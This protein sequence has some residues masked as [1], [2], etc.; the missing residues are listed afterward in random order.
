MNLLQHIKFGNTTSTEWR[1]K[2]LTKASQACMRFHGDTF[3]EDRFRQWFLKEWDKSDAVALKLQDRIK[4]KSGRD[5]A[6]CVRGLTSKTLGVFKP[7]PSK[8]TTHSPWCELEVREKW[9][10]TNGDSGDVDIPGIKTAEVQTGATGVALCAPADLKDV[11]S[12]IEAGQPLSDK[13]LALLLPSADKGAFVDAIQESY[14][15]PSGEDRVSQLDQIRIYDPSTKRQGVRSALLFQLGTGVVQLRESGPIVHLAAPVPTMVPVAIGASADWLEEDKHDLMREAPKRTLL[16]VFQEA[17]G[18]S[19]PVASWGLRHHAGKSPG[20]EILVKIDS[21][22]VPD[23]VKTSG[24][25]GLLLRPLPLEDD[26]ARTWAT[27]PAPRNVH[28]AS[29]FRALYEE[30]SAMDGFR[31]FHWKGPGSPLRIRFAAEGLAAARKKY[32]TDTSYTS[33][34]E[35]MIVTKYFM[36]EGV[37]LGFTEKKLVEVL[38]GWGWHVIV[39]RPAGSY[40]AGDRD[41]MNWVVGS[42]GEPPEGTTSITLTQVD[43]SSTQRLRPIFIREMERTKKD[44]PATRSWVEDFKANPQPGNQ[45][46]AMGNRSNV[47]FIGATA[48]GPLVR[49]SPPVPAPGSDFFA[50]LVPTAPS[51]ML[52]SLI[53]SEG[54]GGAAASAMQPSPAAGPVGATTAPKEDPLIGNDPWAKAIAQKRSR[55]DRSTPGRAPGRSSEPISRQRRPVTTAGAAAAHP[56]EHLLAGAPPP[57]P[58]GAAPTSA[59]VRGMVEAIVREQT[60]PLQSQLTDL[61][62][63]TANDISAQETRLDAMSSR[64]DGVQSDTSAIPQ[65]N[66]LLSAIAAQLGVHAA[67]APTAPPASEQREPPPPSPAPELAASLTGNAADVSPAAESLNTG[68]HLG[69]PPREGG[70]AARRTAPY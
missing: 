24:K 69:E 54:T 43:G 61:A 7:P 26:Q 34:T 41:L 58:E 18:V 55:A 63:R 13:P 48:V 28:D 56:P 25:S 12:R 66:S 4:S 36:L 20:A 33:D 31:G 65:M 47:P 38:D 37:P 44:I 39:S 16:A 5:L 64:L 11:L 46:D 3:V 62:R 42:A 67:A 40:R 2:M 15:N 49:A 27:V 70:A 23:L 29:A 32:D 35:A 52:A 50:G 59:A 60:A 9:S 17:C 1:D 10:A 51:P 22:I 6:N 57:W 14:G 53:G 45:D 21:T 30:A 68:P 19:G 8:R